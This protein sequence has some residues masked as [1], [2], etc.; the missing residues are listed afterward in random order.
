MQCK[1][2]TNKHRNKRAN[3]SILLQEKTKRDTRQTRY[4][5]LPTR[6]LIAQRETEKRQ[7]EGHAI[8]AESENFNTILKSTIGIKG[9][10]KIYDKTLSDLTIENSRL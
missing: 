3:Y 6:A 1:Q 10:E 7:V 9:K 2:L 4:L 5:N 8:N